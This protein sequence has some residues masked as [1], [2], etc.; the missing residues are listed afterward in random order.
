M[1]HNAQQWEK[2]LHVSGGKLE[3]TK[4][5]WCLILWRWIAGQPLL[6]RIKHNP[7]K[8]RLR[9]SETKNKRLTEIKRIEVDEAQKVLGICI[10]I[11]GTWK[12]EYNNWLEK[13]R[14]FANLVRMAKFNRY[15]AL[16]IF[17]F[18]WTAKVRYPMSIIGFTRKQCDKIESPV[19]AACLSASGISR[20]FPRAVVFA[21]YELGG[22]GWESFHTIQT[23]EMLKIITKH[24]K[25][26]DD[27][28][29]LILVSLQHAQLTAG[30]IQPILEPDKLIPNYIGNIWVYTL[31]TLLVETGLKVRI[32][33]VWNNT[34]NRENDMA[35][36]D[37]WM[38]KYN[39]RIL[40]QLNM[41]RMYLKV[42]TLSDICEIDGTK[43][44]DEVWEVRKPPRNSTLE[45]PYQPKPPRSAIRVWQ[46]A[47]LDFA[48]NNKLLNDPLGNWT[49]E[50]HQQWNYFQQRTIRK[51]ISVVEKVAEEDA[52]LLEQIVSEETFITEVIGEIYHNEDNFD[53][54]KNGWHEGLQLTAATDGGLKHR[55]GSHGYI[56]YE[57]TV[58]HD[59]EFIPIELDSDSINDLYDKSILRGF[60]AEQ[61][62]YTKA[63]STREELLGILSIFY[64]MSSC[65]KL[66]GNPDKKIHL[67]I[68]IDS[69]AAKLIRTR[70]DEEF[71]DADSHLLDPDMDIDEEI[72]RVQKTLH[73]IEVAYIWTKSHV[74]ITDIDASR[75]T[76]LNCLADGLATEARDKTLSGSLIPVTH[77]V[78]PAQK[79]G[80]MIGTDVVHNDMMGIIH[81]QCTEKRLHEYLNQKFGWSQCTIDKIHWTAFSRAIKTY[82]A[83]KKI[84]ML[85]II[86]GWQH[87]NLLKYRYAISKLGSTTTQSHQ[88]GN[89]FPCQVPEIDS[90]DYNERFL[91]STDAN[92]YQ[93]GLVLEPTTNNGQNSANATD[94]GEGFQ[95]QASEIERDDNNERSPNSSDA[96]SSKTGL[97]IES[98]TNTVQNY[99]NA[100]DTCEV[101]QSQVPGIESSDNI[102]RF[103]NGND[104][105]SPNTG[106]TIE[107]ITNNVQNLGIVTDH[108]EGLQRQTSAIENDDNHESLPNSNDAHG[109]QKRV[110]IESPPNNVQNLVN[111]TDKREGSQRQGLVIEGIE[112]NDNSERFPNSDDAHSPT[113]GLIIEPTFNNG[114][115]SAIVTDTCEGFQSKKLVIDKED[116]IEKFLN[117]KDAH[118]LQSGLENESPINNVQTRINVN[119]NHGGF[120]CQ[121]PAIDSND[122]NDGLLNSNG[123]YSPKTGLVIESITIHGQNS[124]IDTDKSEGFQSKVSEIGRDYNKERSPNGNDVHSPQTGLVSELPTNNVRT[125]VDIINNREGFQRQVPVTESNDNNARFP[126]SNDAHSPPTRLVIDSTTNNVLN[127]VNVTD[128]CAACGETE[129]KFHLF[130][131]SSSAMKKTRKVGWMELKSSMSKCTHE[132]VLFHIYIGL[133]SIMNDHEP[134]QDPVY[135]DDDVKL[136][137][138]SDDQ[139]EIGWIHMFFGRL[140]TKWGRINRELT[141]KEGKKSIDETTWTTKIAKELMKLTEKIWDTRNLE[142]HGN[143]KEISLAERDATANIIRIYYQVI[144]PRISPQDEWLFHQSEKRKLSEPYVNQVAWIEMIERVCAD[145]IEE[146]NI[147]KQP[148][149]HNMEIKC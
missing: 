132:K 68:V 70:R 87:T 30:T 32:R 136:I 95:S 123:A 45:W 33:D 79:I 122:I 75:L 62:T 41:C 128:K 34:L 81:T 51:N 22:L 103:P 31:H 129:T 109:P 120:Q 57:S 147:V 131:C 54:L 93:K 9:Q 53:G 146:H 52:S 116:K 5:F 130:S 25:M 16:R 67:E 37:T 115:N 135:S 99:V 46:N 74:E 17:S 84:K 111:V 29:K 66:L 36:M 106:S 112:S 76:V 13:S 104:T 50:N 43:I 96:Q 117:S 44:I 143:S 88:V 101:F 100:T 20:T 26:N 60:S 8:L 126:N 35:L 145:I 137:E 78:F 90:D 80:V 1:K 127:S 11:D 108:R 97:A 77:D 142:T 82:R 148:E 144:K 134:E 110:A 40:K 72:H 86:Y 24:V 63:T 105:K 7:T 138:C 59:E 27:V 61:L 94:Q 64:I 124:A 71:Y 38:T 102:V 73:N 85:K 19:V 121:V 58:T 113:T 118:S 2:A 141:K 6:V 3:L 139:N 119:D 15:C 125:S 114:Q 149:K 49:C 47:L 140:T 83:E 28:G 21:P 10:S 42:T 23:Q 55:L 98:T 14:K 92:S 65:Q 48:D 107:L 39:I 69:K 4:C 133:H 12:V 56:I 89:G 18:I 91:N